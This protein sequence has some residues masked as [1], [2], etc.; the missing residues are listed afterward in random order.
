[1]PPCTLPL[2]ALALTTGCA[3]LPEH[4]MEHDGLERSYHLFVPED[5]E[6]GAPL[7]LA[8]HGGGGRSARMD[9]FTQGGLTQE[10]AER[11]WVLAFPQG[12]EEGWNDGRAPVTAKDERRAEVDDVGFLLALVDELSSAYEL[13]RTLLLGVSNGGHMAYRL[14]IEASDT[15][16]V[17][18]PVIANHP[19]VHEAGVPANPVSVL[20]M[21]GTEDPLVPYDGGQ[22]TLFGQERGEV[23][24]TDDTIAWWEQA[25]GCTGPR[26]TL[27]LPDLDPDD[28]TRVVLE[29]DRRCD[30][31]SEVTLVRVEGGGHTWP[32]GSQYLP[33]SVI[34]VVSHDIDAS[35]V[36]FDFFDRQVAF[37]P[38]E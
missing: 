11:G 2:F 23:L 32:G 24:S 25:N 28:G 37:E 15:F 13:D 4:T 21:N 38:A 30:R 29:T 14:G 1:M 27:E 17:I 6:P 10:A 5:L 33:E 8:L 3:C 18:A 26:T 31:D 16:D 19:A 34:G 9:R 12:I 35:E 36:I 7:V 20:V 22:V